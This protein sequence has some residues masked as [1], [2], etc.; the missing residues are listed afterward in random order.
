MKGDELMQKP[1]R[2]QTKEQGSSF[3]H[4]ARSLGGGMGVLLSVLL[5]AGSASADVVGTGNLVTYANVGDLSGTN[6]TWYEVEKFPPFFL[7]PVNLGA[8]A[9]DINVMQVPLGG[10]SYGAPAGTPPSGNFFTN[11][12]SDQGVP[13][14]WNGVLHFYNFF[15]NGE[16][17]CTN[18]PYIQDCS[19]GSEL[20]PVDIT[21]VASQLQ[22]FGSF[23]DQGFGTLPLVDEFYRPI[24]YSIDGAQTCFELL[25]GSPGSY[26]CS[27]RVNLNAFVGFETLSGGTSGDPNDS[28]S[29]DVD[30]TF[31]PPGGGL[32]IPVSG[33]VTYDE[34][35][36]PGF[37]TL[38]TSSQ[39]G[40]TIPPN[41]AL[42][43]PGFTEIY[44]DITTTA[45]LPDPP[46]DITICGYYPDAN[47]DGI[48]D[49]T[50]AWE[51]DLRLLHNE[52]DVFEDRTMAADDDLCPFD[53]DTTC[54]NPD[55]PE[56][57]FL[58]INTV[59]NQICARVDSL[60]VFRNAFR[61]NPPE[62]QTL[63]VTGPAALG[64]PVTATVNFCDA[65]WW[66]I[67][68]VTIDWGDGTSDTIAVP[69]GS[70]PTDECQDVSET[71]EALDNY[72]ATGV[73]TVTVTV[74]DGSASD[75]ASDF[76]VIYDPD[77]GFVTGGGWIDS[78]EGAY[79][80]Q[81]DLIGK[82]NFGFVS[83]YKRGADVPTGNTNFQFQ[84]ADLHFKSTSYEWLLIAGAKAKFKGEG[85]INGAG[86]YGFMLTGIDGDLHGGVDKFRIKIWDSSDN[87]IYD[88]K[89]GEDDN[90]EPTALGGG[91][92]VIH[93][94]K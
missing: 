37:T 48:V 70:S 55:T 62:I 2:K 20:E 21:F 47:Q 63:D 81:P 5:L 52:D 35:L 67:H 65:D 1:E 84:V 9:A 85:T 8:P 36:D 39:A 45:K 94:G 54:P 34:V 92:I 91:S 87:I 79:T 26:E 46:T 60:S 50:P 22:L 53:Q 88:N 80:P 75:S 3:R 51:C 69:G 13:P 77:G 18:P 42:D 11:F 66:Q 30:A 76:A 82:A 49:S 38:V 93:N 57:D 90:A 64:E 4:R 33:T 31:V 16:Y 83:K 72:V 23:V 17:V 61:N 24:V 41:F 7:W 43:V 25:P 89:M 56:E 29:V 15:E 14:A 12:F 59:E 27:G 28:V 19:K 73:Y 32:S 58:C 74:T 40:G 71:R 86:S 78:P 44:L 10:G 68:T 6:I